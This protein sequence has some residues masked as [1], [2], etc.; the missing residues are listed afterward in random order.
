MAKTTNK[1]SI[2]VN[3]QEANTLEFELSV[4]GLDKKDSKIRLLITN[5]KTNKICLFNCQHEK[6]Q[7]WTVTIPEDMFNI[8][9]QYEFKL[10][11]I[12][13][14]YFFEIADGTVNLLNNKPEVKITNT[15][16][17]SKTEEKVKDVEEAEKPKIIKKDTKK[18]KEVVLES[19]MSD[20]TNSTAP[21][22]ALLKT[23]HQPKSTRG[24]RRS[25]R[26]DPK[27]LSDIG[28]FSVPGS[29]LQIPPEDTDENPVESIISKIIGKR[30]NIKES[31]HSS[32]FNTDREGHIWIPGLENNNQKQEMVNKQQRIKDILK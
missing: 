23:E 18:L 32:I 27:K 28:S 13:Y 11:C 20:M 7:L 5:T 26:V 21:T 3:P 22:N 8:D 29:P 4:N 24:I 14:N 2:D 1:Q 6:D 19:L 10:E 30:E 17:S 16:T 9:Q 12:I 25:N 31:K 15:T